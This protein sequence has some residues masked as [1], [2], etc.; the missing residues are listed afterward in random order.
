[1]RGG[2]RRHSKATTG[3]TFRGARKWTKTVFSGAQSSPFECVNVCK[4]SSQATSVLSVVQKYSQ[5]AFTGWDS[6][7]GREGGH[8]TVKGL[9]YH[10]H[11]MAGGGI[12]YIDSPRSIGRGSLAL[13]C[14]AERSV[15]KAGGSLAYLAYHAVRLL[16]GTTTHSTARTTRHCRE[17][18][19]L[20]I[21]ACHM[22]SQRGARARYMLP[23]PPPH[24]ANL[25]IMPAAV[26]PEPV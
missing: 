13:G 12:L 1:M 20:L 26:K 3:P 24:Y 15:S 17:V 21:H 7:A 18:L 2:R 6:H 10:L 25:H 16:W 19:E 23:P 8:S 14:L 5:P 11:Q 4:L 22:H 9:S